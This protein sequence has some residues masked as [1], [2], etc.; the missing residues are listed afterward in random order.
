MASVFKIRNKETGKFW[1][2]PN[3]KETWLEGRFAKNAFC[4]W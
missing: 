3:G 2:T 1:K 4:G